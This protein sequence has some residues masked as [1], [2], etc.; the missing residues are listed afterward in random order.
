M[1]SRTIFLLGI[2]AANSGITM[3]VVEPMLPRLAD[4][5]ATTVPAAAVLITA[6]GFAQAASQYY[7]GPFGDR[8]GKLRMATIL[9]ALSAVVSMLTALANDLQALA[10][11]R[12]VTG[13]VATGN[14]T[15]GMAYLSDVTPAASRQ[16]VLARFVS[17]TIIGQ[18]LGPFV[19]GLLTDLFGWRAA[20][21]FLGA[22]FAAVGVLLYVTTRAQWNDGPRSTGPVLSPANHLAV[23]ARPKA[24]AV[25]AAVT[26]EV[27]L[28]FG[29]FAFLGAHLKQ[30][31]DLSFTTIGLLLAGFGAGGVLYTALAHRLLGAM[32]Q[33]GCMLAG[34]AIVAIAY[35]GAVVVPWW[36]LVMACT[37][38]SGF[39]FYLVHNTLQMK[40]TEMA[41]ERRG[42][43]IA[44]FSAGWGGGQAIGAAVM[45][46]LAS[47]LG[48]AVPIVLFGIGFLLLAFVAR[49]NLDRL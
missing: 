5:F 6:F 40:A 22:V 34:G 18:A 19:G 15:L 30:R 44:L 9:M 4:E 49:A 17:G 45:G 27:L 29:A 1:S 47:S 20:F 46:V 21:V 39:G 48:Y 35:A 41:P 26:I 16:P 24:R 37:V 42:T 43:A 3:R 31:F 11:L 2:A 10:I 28:F 13:L 33:R 12:L 36:P 7:H 23:L 8:F 32:G 14:M 25:L 38:A